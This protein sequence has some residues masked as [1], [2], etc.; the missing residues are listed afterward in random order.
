MWACCG[1]WIPLDG[2]H[3]QRPSLNH[4][5]LGCAYLFRYCGRC[6]VF[7]SRL[8]EA[9]RSTRAAS[10]SRSW[11]GSRWGLTIILTYLLP[12]RSASTGFSRVTT[13]SFSASGACQATDAE[14]SETLGLVSMYGPLTGVSY[15]FSCAMDAIRLTYGSGAATFTKVSGGQGGKEGVPFTIDQTLDPIVEVRGYSGKTSHLQWVAFRTR[16][17]A[18]WATE[19]TSDPGTW[20][21]CFVFS[22]QEYSFLFFAPSP[23]LSNREY[24]RF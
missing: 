1:L 14:I 6:T 10:S 9:L 22:E 5:L 3:Y 18:L 7:Y 4:A 15:R 8:V 21:R 24:Q 13:N 20:Y 17:G 12:C 19:S 2:V 11:A 23:R 16:S